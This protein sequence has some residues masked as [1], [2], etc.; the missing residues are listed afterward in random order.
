MHYRDL[1]IRL[2][3]VISR[4]LVCG[5]LPFSRESVGVIYSSSQLGNRGF[6]IRTDHVI[7][8]KRPDLLL[9]NTKKITCHLLNVAVPADHNMKIKD[10]KILGSCQRAETTVEYEGNDETNCSWCP[11]NGS[12]RP[13]KETRGTG[14]QRTT[15]DQPHHYTF[16]IS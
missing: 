2:F 8:A 1:T 9:L 14:G 11:W 13:G 6:E 15:R 12:Q 5:F 7:L 4:I 10:G 3:S 16:N